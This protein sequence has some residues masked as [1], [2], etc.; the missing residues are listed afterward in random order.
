MPGERAK[1]DRA[2]SPEEL[3]HIMRGQ[4]RLEGMEDEDE[5]EI[6]TLARSIA[7]NG[8]RK[9]PIIDVNGILLDGN[10]RVAACYLILNDT[11]GE[12][13]SDEKKRAEYIYVWQLLDGATDDERDRVMVSLNFES[14]CKKDWPEY[15][16]A[17]KV[18]DDWEAMLALEG[19]KKPGQQRLLAQSAAPRPTLACIRQRMEHWLE[20]AHKRL[21]DGPRRKR[22]IPRCPGVNFAMVVTHANGQTGLPHTRD[23][24]PKGYRPQGQAFWD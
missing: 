13:T 7:A 16:K 5:F 21:I 12:F 4:M 9:P 11:S 22:L 15:I 19:P 8:V 14:D 6:V 1:H 20:T 17:R 24:H 18:F 3:L 2:P 10:R 23:P